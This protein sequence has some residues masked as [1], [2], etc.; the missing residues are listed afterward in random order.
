LLKNRLLSIANATGIDVVLFTSFRFSR[1][2]L[3]MIDNL[4]IKTAENDIPLGRQEF[5][6]KTIIN[7]ASMVELA[8]DFFS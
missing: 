7:G 4:I 5:V 1:T 8:D 2:Q 3:A 6:R